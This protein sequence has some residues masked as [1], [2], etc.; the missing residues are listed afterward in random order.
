MTDTDQGA[1]ITTTGSRIVYEN[2]WMRVREDSVRR[3][4][5][6]AGIY[7]VI[8]KTD[9][10]IV[11]AIQDGRLHL[12]E[13]YRYP[14]RRRCWELPQGMWETRPGT[15]HVTLARAELREETGLEAAELA[16]AGRLFLAAG[17]CTQ[18][19]HIYRATGLTRGA[20]ALDPE[21]QDLVTRDFALEEVEA[22][23]RDGVIADTSTIAAL[24]LL[25]IKGLL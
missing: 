3:R 5:G 21:E 15:D 17:M 18:C 2:R 4:D 10:V 6:S 11:A 1:D 20:N 9:F 25:R 8:E 14:V 19:S 13:Q 22:M 24:G 16:Y 7:G 23:I 12:V